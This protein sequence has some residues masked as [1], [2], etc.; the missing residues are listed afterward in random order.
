M[1]EIHSETGRVASGRVGDVVADLIFFL[2]AQ[3]GKSRDGRD[4]LVIAE[5]LESGNSLGCGTEGKR[6][7]EAEIGVAGLRQVEIANAQRERSE[8][9]R[10][11]N[12]L[13]AQHDVEVVGMR[14]GADGRKCGLL[15]ERVVGDVGVNARAQE[16]GGVRRLRPI[17][18]DGSEIVSKRYRNIIRH[19]DGADSRNQP[20][21]GE[22]RQCVELRQTA[23]AISD[24]GVFMNVLK[25]REKPKLVFY[26][27]TAE[28]PDVILL[29]EWLLGQRGGIL[30]RIPR[31]EIGGA[32]VESR[33][34]M[35]LVSAALGGDLHRAAHGAADVRIL[36]RRLDREFLNRVGREI[37]QKAADVIV[38][39]VHAIHGVHVVQTRTS[40]EADCG[41]AR[42]GGIRWFHRLCSRNQISD[43]GEAALGERKR[44][45]IARSHHATVNGACS[46]ERLRSNGRWRCRNVHLLLRRG[47]VHGYA[48]IARRTHIYR[49]CGNSVR[50]PGGLHGDAIGGRREI[51]E[52]KLAAIVTLGLPF[53]GGFAGADGDD[54]RR[55]PRAAG[56]ADVADQAAAEILRPAWKRERQNQ[57]KII[58]RIAG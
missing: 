38:R 55:D 42:L 16:P 34:A 5:R 22:R 7:G 1:D 32:F 15:D 36:L 50:E 44:V 37:L 30:N 19:R 47:G 35:P 45:E 26:N 41:D 40:A 3:D 20:L 13:L 39:V 52:T 29:G 24:A 27:G 4:E 56:I 23:R 8:P 43:V 54:G 17:E 58:E 46:V 12:I 10:A 48:N 2:I 33:S 25:R 18:S 57:S 53:D 11:E 14:G 28:C 21:R 31:V 49:D 9:R 51:A 6:Q